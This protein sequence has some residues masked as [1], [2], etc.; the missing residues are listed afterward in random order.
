MPQ[1]PGFALLALAGAALAVAGCAH[2]PGVDP[3][4]SQKTLLRNKTAVGIM[5]MGIPG[6]GCI[7]T[8]IHIG[9]RDGNDFEV[10][11]RLRFLPVP[12][13]AGDQC[14]PARQ[15]RGR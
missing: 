13:S 4:L 15:V 14:D 6:E 10:V 1:F 7:V 11:E 5:Q 12:G 2:T 9:R 8:T 3:E